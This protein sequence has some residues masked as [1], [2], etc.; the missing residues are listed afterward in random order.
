MIAIGVAVVLT[1]LLPQSLP[2]GTREPSGIAYDER[3]GRLIVVGDEGTLAILDPRTRRLESWAVG[4]NLEDVAVHSPSGRLVL[5]GETSRVL[6]VYDP[7]GKRVTG[8]FDLDRDA[9]LGDDTDADPNHGFEGLAFREEAERPGGGVFYLVHQRSPVML[10]ALAFDPSAA[11]GRLGAD[12]VV[13]RWPIEELPD[14]TAVTYVKALDRLLVLSSRADRVLVLRRDGSA[15]GYV[16]LSGA[17]QEGIAV[18]A[19]GAL[20]VADDRLGTVRRIEGG[21]D[22][23]RAPEMDTDG[24][25]RA[26]V[27]AD[28][29]SSGGK[30]DKKKD[31]Q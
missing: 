11:E 16:P 7:D 14:A 9:I 29:E 8:R 13:G 21:L 22:R 4:G 28:D 25:R 30:K 26:T 23:L 10:V 17:Q 1:Q 12:A 27:P 15:D 6:V 20:W 2:S 31:K 18:D 19:D 24:K 3:R 5:L